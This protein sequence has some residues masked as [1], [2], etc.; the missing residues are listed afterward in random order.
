MAAVLTQQV[1]GHARR[2]LANDPALLVCA[3]PGGRVRSNG[4]VDVLCWSVVNLGENGEVQGS[5]IQQNDSVLD[6]R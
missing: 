6:I 4:R 1:V 5:A 3:N 2:C